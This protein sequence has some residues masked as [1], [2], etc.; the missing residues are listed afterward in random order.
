MNFTVV[1]PSLPDIPIL[2]VLALKAQPAY[3]TTV[4]DMWIEMM[5]GRNTTVK[6]AG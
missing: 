1:T 5:P 6:G 2:R 4:T 3:P